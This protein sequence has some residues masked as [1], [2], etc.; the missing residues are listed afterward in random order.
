MSL[1]TNGRC[2]RHAKEAGMFKKTKD[3]PAI[4]GNLVENKGL[5]S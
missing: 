3:L 5:G 2:G 4:S 1:K